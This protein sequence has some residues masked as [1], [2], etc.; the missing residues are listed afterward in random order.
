[1]IK[2]VILKSVLKVFCNFLEYRA[3][4]VLDIETQSY[5]HFIRLSGLEQDG[6]RYAVNNYVYDSRVL[7]KIT[8]HIFLEWNLHQEL[9]RSWS[10][11]IFASFLNKY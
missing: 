6:D 11:F 10:Y 2:T 5:N 3:Y 9:V 7:A 4:W 1:M 8:F